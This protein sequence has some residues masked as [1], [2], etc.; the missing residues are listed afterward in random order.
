MYRLAAELG[1][2]EII[3][4]QRDYVKEKEEIARIK[5]SN[6]IDNEPDQ[7]KRQKSAMSSKCTPTEID[8]I[9]KTGIFKGSGKNPYTTTLN[10]CTCRDY[11]VRK[12]PCKHIY[13]LRYELN[14]R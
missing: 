10:S 6:D 14:N 13:R 12:L 5:S 2:I 4:R 11:F 3:R 8:H 1:L 9:N 7:L